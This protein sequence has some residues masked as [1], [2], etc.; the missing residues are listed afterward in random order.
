MYYGN[1]PFL[2]KQCSVLQTLPVLALTKVNNLNEKLLSVIFAI[3]RCSWLTHS[4]PHLFLHGKVLRQ[5]LRE[6]PIST[7]S[8][9]NPLS[10]PRPPSPTP[11]LHAPGR[12]ILD[13]HE[14]IQPKWFITIVLQKE[15][16]YKKSR[17]KGPL[18]W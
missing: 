7:K 5:I 10:I 18:C 3:Y 9:G 12:K 15:D 11:M 4:H 17:W 2:T 8:W 13:Q 16:V 6:S 14:T 1:Q